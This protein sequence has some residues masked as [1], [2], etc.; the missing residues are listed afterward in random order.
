MPAARPAC[1]IPASGGSRTGF[2]LMQSRQDA[3]P[4][5]TLEA[6]ESWVDRAIRDARERGDFNALSGE[7]KPL[8]VER[9]PLAGDR[10]LGFH[11]LKNADLLPHWMQLAKDVT[12]GLAALDRYQQQCRERIELLR[13]RV[14]RRSKPRSDERGSTLLRW[15]RSGFLDWGF[16]ESTLDVEG[17][18][19]ERRHRQAR[20]VERAAALDKQIEEY[21]AA[22]P[23]DL[24][25]L[26][27][28]RLLPDRAAAQFDA[29][30]PSV[31]CQSGNGP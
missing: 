25:W 7:G 5:R 26:E 4:E 18:E 14:C 27:R 2:E 23:N 21:N 20:Y 3:R 12:E 8:R 11:V 16:G 31:A 6:W 13:G 28:P 17:V 30:C 29:A 24:R 22:L 9:N 15:L 10:E 1:A 19:R